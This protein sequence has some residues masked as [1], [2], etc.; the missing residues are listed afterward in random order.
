MNSYVCV[1]CN[2]N[3]IA[4]KLPKDCL[5]P[6]C[7]MNNLLKDCLHEFESTDGL[8]VTDNGKDFLELN[9]KQLEDKIKKEL[10]SC[11][12]FYSDK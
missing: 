4:E 10:T 12:P 1:E 11:T 9:N 7:R 3:Y 6:K 8:K 2:Q 5:C